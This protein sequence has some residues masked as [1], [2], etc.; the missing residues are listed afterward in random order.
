MAPAS[1]A[2][3]TVHR[4][5]TQ[6]A[7]RLDGEPGQWEASNPGGGGA[8][9]A[10]G[11]GPNG[12]VLA[13]SDLSGVYRSRDRGKNWDDI[14]VRHGLSQTHASSVG[15][16][17]QNGQILYI[18]TEDGIF[19]STNGGD[20]VQQ[21]LKGGY[22]S[23]IKFA[24]S[25]P[26]IGYAGYHPE[27]N[28]DQGVVYKSTDRGMTWSKISSDLPGKLRI[29]KLIVHP[30]DPNTI[31]L[32]SG[33]ARFA[34]GVKAVFKST[35][36]GVHW[37]QIGAD[38]GA[39][40]D[41]ALDGNAPEVLYLTSYVPFMDGE[42]ETY[43]EG[44]IHR[45]T[46]GGT[47]W[48]KMA[49]RTGVIWIDRD[50][51]HAIRLIQVDHQWPWD[52]ASNGVWE[53][54]D[55]AA[56]WTKISKVDDW[57]MG[58]VQAYWSYAAG[59]DGPV[60]SLGEDLSDP[61]A[62]WWTNTQWVHA[63]F[64]DGRSFAT[65]HTG[66]VTPDHWRSRGFDNVVA[67]D[68]AISPLDS[69]LYV[70]YYDIG[71][72]HSDDAIA[73]WQICNHPDYTWSQGKGGNMITVAADPSRAGVVWGSQTV[74]LGTPTVLLRSNNGAKSWTL[75]NTGLPTETVSGLSIDVT[76]SAKQRA[77]FVAGNGDVYQSSDD[78]F[79]WAKRFDCNGCRQT[80]VDLFD[81][82]LVYAGGEAGLWRSTTG[83][84]EGS[85][86]QIGPAELVGN[87]GDGFWSSDWEGVNAI[88]PDPHQAHWLY[89][90]AFGRGR[91]IYRSQDGGDSWEK[92]WSNDFARS[93]AISPVD[94]QRI[95]VTSSSSVNRG[96]Y[97]PSSMGVM[98]SV[99]GGATWKQVNDGLEWP[100]ANNILFD[101]RNPDMV[102][103]DSAGT[104]VQKRNFA[105]N[106]SE[107]GNLVQNGDFHQ[108]AV[109][110]NIWGNGVTSKSDA[111]EL[112]LYFAQPLA[113][114][115]DAGVDQ[116]GIRLEQD[117]HY[118]LNM[119]LWS[120]SAATIKL[121]IGES[122]EPWTNYWNQLVD[123][124]ADGLQNDSFDF[125]MN[126][127]SD[128]NTG[129]Y[130]HIGGHNSSVICM[131]QISLTVVTDTANLYLPMV[132]R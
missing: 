62:L 4:A 13:A 65:Q 126:K 54:T 95:F 111:G 114:F 40:M 12:I 26:Q 129:L 110:W 22:I 71:C 83:G 27:W 96:V 29:L 101:P 46:D 119:R 105:S 100:F 97:D 99:D 16:D 117:K 78:G 24:P 115:W 85:W 2:P 14:G 68:M 1:T 19:R 116:Q 92:I 35:D 80:A 77:L 93:I 9:A 76:S 3:L 123:L 52:A 58:W 124:S 94:G 112:C 49:D 107:N 104:G 18:G 33:R 102:Y 122:Q 70:G 79:T 42:Y 103:I 118:R 108:D 11:A 15:F 74:D 47:S 37:S 125:T 90:A 98:L 57:G 31:Y 120:Q 21:V 59:F 84:D 75:S 88:V 48:T 55:N 32:L 50:D 25:D 67:L 60:K 128:E 10:I 73:S 53:S 91:G 5:L 39:V 23:E 61:D 8:F 86:R 20:S 17:P 64:D 45:S 30:T 38:R 56:H 131:D 72:W 34:A 109:G 121:I 89:V 87:M 132:K 106:G 113:N 130:F 66:E 81:G 82:N 69:Q 7:T 41:I 127:S 43:S 63:T 36:G 28:S 44:A 51:Q 6:P